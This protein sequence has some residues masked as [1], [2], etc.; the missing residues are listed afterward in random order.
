[1]IYLM[2]LRRCLVL[3]TK[4]SIFFQL[5]E[6]FCFLANRLCSIAMCFSCC[7]KLFTGHITAPFDSAAKFAIPTSIPTAYV[8]NCLGKHNSC[9]THIET[10][11][12]LPSLNMVAFFMLPITFWLLKN[13]TQ[14]SLG[15]L[16]LLC[17]NSIWLGCGNLKH[18]VYSFYA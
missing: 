4:L 8:G 16:I 11:Q 7:L 14:P 9:S 12:W 18:H 3:S 5:L 2:M 17:S 13:L 10:Y 6:N 1:M 15:N